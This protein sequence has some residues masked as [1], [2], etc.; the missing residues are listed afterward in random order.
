MWQKLKE[1]FKWFPVEKG[2]LPETVEV[3]LSRPFL[4]GQ[5]PTGDQRLGMTWKI[6]GIKYG[7]AVDAPSRERAE[8]YLYWEFFDHLDFMGIRRASFEIQDRSL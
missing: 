6:D 3:S 7:L 8:D 2:G 4:L 5:W 1:R